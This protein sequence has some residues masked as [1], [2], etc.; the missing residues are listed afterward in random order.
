[1]NNRERKRSRQNE[2]K[3]K[4]KTGEMHVKG[5]NKYWDIEEDETN[6]FL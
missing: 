6:I 3:G 5:R 1:V 2:S 4:K